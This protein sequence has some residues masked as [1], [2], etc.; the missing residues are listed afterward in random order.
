MTS[1]SATTV[2]GAP[3]Y[4]EG[5]ARMLTAWSRQSSARRRCASSAQVAGSSPR[6][7]SRALMSTTSGSRNC[8]LKNVRGLVRWRRPES[9]RSSGGTRTLRHIRVEPRRSLPPRPPSSRGPSPCSTRSRLCARSCESSRSSPTTSRR[10]APSRLCA[11]RS[12]DTRAKSRFPPPRSTRALPRRA[13]RGTRDSR[14]W[15]WTRSC[16]AR[17]TTT[18]RRAPRP[19]A[20]SPARRW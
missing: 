17:S 7:R 4:G 9:T 10:P 16:A 20:G 3:R 18:C 5:T 11:R 12:L 1:L 19:L 13:A 15:S 6:Q 8:R 14:R 2:S